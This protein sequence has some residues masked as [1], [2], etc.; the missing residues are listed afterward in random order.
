MITV[1]RGTNCRT[2]PGDPYD[3]VGDLMVNETAEVV[4]VSPDGGTWIIKNPDGPGECWLWGYYATVTGPTTGLP[5]YPL[6][7]TPT[8]Q[9]F[10]TGTWDTINYPVGGMGL[11]L[12]MTTTVNGRN[13]AGTMT[14]PGVAPVL[15]S[16]TISDDWLSVSGTWT[17]SIDTGTFKFFAVGTDRFNGSSRNAEIKQWCGVRGGGPFPDPCFK[18]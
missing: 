8:P 2:G 6:P 11:T 1:S 5:V 14:I 9:F 16:G 10:W 4:G 15:L 7:P 17:S 3:I 12:S 18:E 13:F